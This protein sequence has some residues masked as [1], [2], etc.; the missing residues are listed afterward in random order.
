VIIEHA[1]ARRDARGSHHFRRIKILQSDD[2]HPSD[3][4]E[5]E[6]AKSEREPE[7]EY[8]RAGG[9]PED[10]ERPTQAAHSP[11]TRT[12]A[13]AVAAAV[14]DAPPKPRRSRAKK[15]PAENEAG[16]PL[17]AATERV[18]AAVEDAAA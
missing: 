17:D 4:E 1:R 13:A 7:P 5:L 8:Q 10:P 3:P 12:A 16:S 18:R 6:G 11:R 9:G 2:L 14:A 15:P